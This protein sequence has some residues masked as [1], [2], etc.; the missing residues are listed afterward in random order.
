MFTIVGKAWHFVL[1]TKFALAAK[2]VLK[3]VKTSFDYLQAYHIDVLEALCL[4]VGVQLLKFFI[5][6]A[7][8]LVDALWFLTELNEPLVVGHYSL[9]AKHWGSGIFI[10]LSTRLLAGILQALL[11]I[12]HYQFLAK[13]INETLCP[14]SD[15]K[16]IWLHAGKP[17][18]IAYH[19]APQAAGGGDNHGV[20][21]ACLN[22]L[23]RHHFAL[24]CQQSVVVYRL[25]RSKLVEHIIIEHEHHA[26]VR[27]VVLQAEEAF[28][29][30][31]G[32]H[33]VHVALGDK[34][35]ILLAIGSEGYATMKEHLEVWP[36]FLQVLLARK[37]HNSTEHGHHPRGYATDVGD[38]GFETLACYHLTLTVKLGY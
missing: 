35:L 21:L 25:H 22:P 19:I 26:A 34:L 18:R 17:D 4:I 6:Y 15:D 5:Q 13:G 30:I 7:G 31:V 37:F 16:L 14:A 20:V 9:L 10:Y 1:S 29:G 24:V 28:R 12:I 32:L 38:I 8:K 3:L 33:V 36:Y 27:R 11:R 23:Y 2:P